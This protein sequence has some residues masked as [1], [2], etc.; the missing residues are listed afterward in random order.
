M[1]ISVTAPTSITKQPSETRRYSMSFTNLMATSE[2]ISNLRSVTSELRGGG[3]SDLGIAGTGISG[4]TI[5]MNVSSGTHA[6][7][8]A[9]EVQITTSSGQLLE[10]DGILKVEDR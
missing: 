2:T 8:Y 3:T 10:G 5:Y 4:Q 9:I 7:V 1:S 6:Q